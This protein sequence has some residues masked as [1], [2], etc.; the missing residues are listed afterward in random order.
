MGKKKK[1]AKE[2]KGKK[3]PRKTKSSEK[4]KSYE[5]GKRKGKFCIKC[6]PGVFMGKHK[7]RYTCGKCGYT[8]FIK[9]DTV[10]TKPKQEKP[11]SE[12]KPKPTE[13]KK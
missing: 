3:A 6:G 10:E 13:Q 8:E 5:A 11:K 7:N 9:K 12:S 1:R 2:K 4:W